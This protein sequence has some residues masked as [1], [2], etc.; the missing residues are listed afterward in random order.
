MNGS[1]P[2]EPTFV[3]VK[4]LELTL[5]QPLPSLAAR[6]AQTPHGR[7]L[8]LVRLHD[9]ALGLVQAEIPPDGLTADDLAQ[10]VWDALADSIVGHLKRDGL[11]PT[12]RLTGQGIAPGSSE[13]RCQR[14]RRAFLESEAPEMTVLIPSR[15]RPQ[16]LRR[17][18]ES[19]LQCDY[20]ASRFGIIVVDN[21]PE[22]GDTRAV[23]EELALD[24]GG[25][26]RYAREDTPGSASAR[27]RGLRLVGTELL[28]MT[29][30]DVIV[31]RHW[32]T[33][34]ARAFAAYPEAGAVSGLLVPAEL[35]SAAQLWFEQYGGFSRGFE[36]RVFDLAANRP[37]DEPLYP[38]N[39]GLFGTGNNFSFR[40]DTLVSIG[41]FDPA[42]GNGTPA[43]G[44][45]D[46]EV[47]LRTILSGHQIVYEP[48][49]IAHHAHRPDYAA[50]RRQIYA[51]GAG[52]VAYYL[53]TILAEPRFAL[54]FARKLPAGIRW[55]MSPE[56]HVNKHKLEDY[57][58]QLVWDERRGM[59]YGPLAYARSR[60]RY[61]PH[62]VY[63]R[64]L[65]TLPQSS[66]GHDS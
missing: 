28:A 2:P 65:S 63:R 40:T 8:A 30:D 47:L 19:I 64:R 51:Y 55:M 14:L 60:R 13:P 43:L 6:S 27:N 37:A 44:G 54:D 3:P 36:R 42:L 31:D 45:V 25:R 12:S 26:V 11:E 17:C 49:A 57:P 53:K 23:V 20:P 24:T 62:P 33:E 32:L 61:G 46:S 52:L 10:I 9:T 41:G 48:N 38:W 22:T 7:L 1:R 5:E 39:A 18:L 34:I 16:R 50:L 66:D 15:E 29:D 4:V 21:A 58:S 56:S 35:E 59:L